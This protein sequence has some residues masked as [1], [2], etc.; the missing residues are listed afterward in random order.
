LAD[1]VLEVVREPVTVSGRRLVTTISVGIAY[2]DERS[3]PQ[4]LLRD[5]DAAVYRS[6]GRGRNQASEFD[7]ALRADAVARLEIE[8]DLRV[9]LDAGQLTVVYQPAF[10]AATGAVAGVEARV[11][12]HHPT[13]RGVSPAEFIPLAE[14]TGLIVPV[15][16]R[17]LEVVGTDLAAGRL[18]TDGNWTVWVNVSGRELA[19]PSYVDAVRRRHHELGGRLGLEVTETV[20]HADPTAAGAA[21]ARLA[22]AGVKIA[23]DDFGTGYSSL[24]RL[25]DYP[26]DLVKIDQ[27]F[28]AQ[29]ASGKHRAI[30][31][32]AVEL[33]HALGASA[34]AEGVETADQLRGV[35]LLGCDLVSGYHLARPVPAAEV[36]DA[37]AHG[38]RTITAAS[39]SA[40]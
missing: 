28:V 7:D 37:I 5:A 33:S 32:A 17:V 12:W 18:G 24:A 15:G 23:I 8:N 40:R 22:A 9:A 10:D 25:T 13:P 27:S 30:V 29:L 11:R 20:L 4:T 35:Q 39:S 6:K 38:R 1:R 14:E 3:T 16:Q 2:C 36:P 26:I 31:A 19:E 21:L 34:V